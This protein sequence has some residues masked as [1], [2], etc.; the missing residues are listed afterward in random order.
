MPNVSAKIDLTRIMD[1]ASYDAIRETFESQ[2]FIMTITP[3]DGIKVP[4]HLDHLRGHCF[5]SGVTPDEYATLKQGLA[6]FCKWFELEN[7]PVSPIWSEDEA[8]KPAAGKR[9]LLAD[10]AF[11]TPDFTHLQN[12]LENPPLG[13]GAHTIHATQIPG[14]LGE[15]VKVFDIE[16]GWYDH[17]DRGL[18]YHGVIYGSNAT[19]RDHGTAVACEICGNDQNG[20]G[21]KGIAPGVQFYSIS[22][23]AGLARSLIEVLKHVD[24]EKDR[25]IVGV[26]LQYRPFSEFNVPW[27][28]VPPTQFSS[29]RDTI[30]MLTDQ[31]IHVMLA[32]SNGAADLDDPRFNGVFQEDV[33]AIMVGAGSR[34]DHAP[35]SFTGY[36]SPVHVQG[37]GH[38]V[39]TGGYGGLWNPGDPTRT[40]TETFNGTSSSL[41]K[42]MACGAIALALLE[43]AGKSTLAPRELRKL[44]IETGTPQKPDYRHIGPFPNLIRL[45]HRLIPGP[46][47]DLDGMVRF[48]DFIQFASYY[49]EG[50]L[51]A[52]LNGD[53]VVDFQDFLVF[54]QHFNGPAKWVVMQ[55]AKFAIRRI[56]GQKAV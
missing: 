32:A 20:F 37:Q 34:G 13:L 26:E 35:L 4:K 40:Y 25:V 18:G 16:Y 45:K 24:P 11:S 15:N 19:Y 27:Q 47:Y 48:N 8:R 55:A 28:Y 2:G 51:G 39:T 53:G 12:H 36:G 10:E 43:A 54:A 1:P 21:I 14:R 3:E 30:R 41:P 49:Q 52:D 46:D 44:L 29:Y 42:A 23:S 56:D 9:A 33:G 17:E 22:N 7:D 31:G 50:N 6:K 38:W 5:K